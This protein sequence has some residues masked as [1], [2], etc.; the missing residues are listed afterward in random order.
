MNYE[1]IEVERRSPHLGAWIRG[2]DLREEL[3]DSAI[4]EIRRALLEYHVIFFREQPIT[5]EQHLAFAARFGDLDNPHPVFGSEDRIDRR[6]TVIESKGRASDAC[7]AQPD[8][9]DLQAGFSKRSR[10]HCL[11]SFL[12]LVSQTNYTLTYYAEHT[13]E[14]SHDAVRQAYLGS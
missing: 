4:A 3:D 11:S 12:L 9:G 7:G 8:F 5:G 14:F 1:K 6:L 10:F 2:V 13:E